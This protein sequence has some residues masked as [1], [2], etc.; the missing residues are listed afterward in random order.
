MLCICCEP[1][2]EKTVSKQ[3]CGFFRISVYFYEIFV[4]MRQY[5]FYL[6]AKFVFSGTV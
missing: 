5:Q 3:I 1:I 6:T 2:T 4:G